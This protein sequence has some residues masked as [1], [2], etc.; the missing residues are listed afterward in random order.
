M[1]RFYCLQNM[2][3]WLQGTGVMPGTQKGRKSWWASAWGQQPGLRP[4]AAGPVPL[5][6]T[7][8][9]GPLPCL[10]PG[11]GSC[12]WFPGLWEPPAE[13]NP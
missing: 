5:G 11:A 9:K 3:T 10:H 4:L 8:G 2:A 1:Q 13:G 6:S 7:C 12:P